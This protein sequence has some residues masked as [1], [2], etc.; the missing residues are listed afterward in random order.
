MRYTNNVNSP[1]F[2]LNTPTA[3]VSSL[4]QPPQLAVCNAQLCGSTPTLLN[5]SPIVA[6]NIDTLYGAFSWDLGPLTPQGGGAIKLVLPGNNLTRYASAVLYDHYTNVV[7]EVSSVNQLPSVP[8]IFC[9][10]Q[11]AAHPACASLKQQTGGASQTI[12]VP[13]FGFAL[14]RVFSLG[15]QTGVCGMDGCQ[16]LLGVAQNFAVIFPPASVKYY[17]VTYD[18]YMSVN[19]AVPGSTCPSFPN[20]PLTPP[21]GNGNKNAFW[22]AL[23]VAIADN[24]VTGAE[25]T[26]VE[27]TFGSLGIHPN[28]CD[29]PLDYATL[30]AGLLTGFQYVTSNIENTG[31]FRGPWYSFPFSGA[32]NVQDLNSALQRAV[33]ANRVILINANTQAVYWVATKDSNGNLLN[34]AWGATYKVVWKSSDPIVNA[35]RGFWSVTLY[36]STRFLYD[37]PAGTD[38]R[39]YAV[40]GTGVPSGDIHISMVCRTANCI[41]GPPGRFGLGLRAYVPLANVLPNGNYVFP[42]I[43]KCDCSSPCV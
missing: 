11:A 33:A 32:W 13:R 34:S 2:A 40:R 17:N 8:S 20:S 12:V 1:G 43:I 42:D 39:Q 24:P 7:L 29:A 26:Y 27:N 37:P 30:N 19:P 38:Q 23:C 21:C 5:P 15:Q 16:Y 14:I 41:R 6:P 10:T 28:H 4:A 18:A 3:R 31:V 35:Q 22:D 9:L 25:A 36:D